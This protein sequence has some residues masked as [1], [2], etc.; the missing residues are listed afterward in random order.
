MTKQNNKMYVC[1]N[2]K[3]MIYLTKQ[4]IIYKAIREDKYK[5]NN[6]V[7]LYDRN[8]Q[9]YDK[10]NEYKNKTKEETKFM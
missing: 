4:D 5:Q 9:L 2:M 7:W 10:I 3:L 8:E 1:T 6:Y